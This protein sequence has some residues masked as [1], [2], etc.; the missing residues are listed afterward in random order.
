MSDKTITNLCMSLGL[1]AAILIGIGEYMLHFMPEGPSGEISMLFSVP[2]GRA[3]IGH[4]IATATI[5]LYFFGYYGLYRL[6]RSSNPFYALGLFILG[7]LSFTYGGVWI[8]SRYM[9]AVVFQGTQ[10]TDLFATMLHQY[11]TSYQVLVW[12]LRILVLGIS[13]FYVMCILKNKI[14]LPKWLVAFN[15]II[16]LGLTISTL[17]WLRP[18][19]VHLAPIAM[20]TTHFVFFAL[21]LIYSN[22]RVS[23]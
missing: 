8:S 14:N 16:L 21:L 18:V 9:A 2:L 13:F 5:P 1:L 3:Q 12:A 22:K 4:F 20:N 19:G 15:P 11:E 23:A 6:F 17:A 7:I 10:G